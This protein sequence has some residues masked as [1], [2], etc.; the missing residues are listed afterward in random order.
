VVF[1]IRQAEPFTHIVMTRAFMVSR[2]FLPL[3]AVLPEQVLNRLS[4]LN[5]VLVFGRSLTNLPARHMSL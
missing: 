4:S 2:P 5:P 1:S 3:L